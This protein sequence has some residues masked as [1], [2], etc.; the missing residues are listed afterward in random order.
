MHSEE[1]RKGGQQD[2]PGAA[3]EAAASCFLRPCH[4]S[5]RQQQQQQQQQQRQQQQQQRQQQQR[6]VFPC[7]CSEQQRQLQAGDRRSPSLPFSSLVAASLWRQLRLSP[8]ASA[9]SSSRC[10]SR[11]P[12]SVF[13]SLRLGRGET[14]CVLMQQQQQ[15]QQQQDWRDRDTSPLLRASKG[16]GSSSSSR[17]P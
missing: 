17:K 3:Q 8:P 5:G 13:V 6:P 14:A 9:R 2:S 1:R 15:Q 16:L 12:L 10:I 7:C 4:S 11:L